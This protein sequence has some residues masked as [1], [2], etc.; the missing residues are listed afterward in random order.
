MEQIPGSDFEIWNKFRDGNDYS[1]SLIY[2]KYAEVLYRYGLKFTGNRNIIE[3]SIHDMFMDL[4][5]NRK[6]IG[7]T[8]NIQFYLL[9]TFR[10]KLTRKLKGEL[11]Y[12]D[13]LASEMIFDIH[14]SAESEMISEEIKNNQI[15]QLHKAIN[16]LSPRQKE[17]IYLKFQK[18]LDYNEISEILGMGIEACRNLIY[19]AI[20]S[21]RALVPND[22]NSPVLLLILKNSKNILKYFQF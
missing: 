7:E 14:Y 4:I 10:R 2:S 9:R 1:L 8:T 3:D 17:A 16:N 18:E 11:R 22:G 12:G 21:L 19:R 5:R 13:D 15:K 20:K 6:T